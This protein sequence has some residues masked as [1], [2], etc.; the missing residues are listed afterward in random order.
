MPSDNSTP[1][2][3]IKGFD[4]RA[5]QIGAM[6]YQVWAAPAAFGVVERHSR[7]FD[8]IRT[9]QHENGAGPRGKPQ[10]PIENPKSR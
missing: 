4:Q 9:P 1:R 3:A 5:L 2:L 8:V 6:N 10:H 7:K